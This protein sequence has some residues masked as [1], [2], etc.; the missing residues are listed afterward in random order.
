MHAIQY[1]MARLIVYYKKNF[2]ADATQHCLMA[3]GRIDL[4]VTRST[5]TRW[6]LNDIV[7]PA[8]AQCL[9]PES[10]ESFSAEAFFGRE[11]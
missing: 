2:C 3:G 1:I 6:Q 5:C 11:A 10:A 4:L 7:P 8:V 9:P